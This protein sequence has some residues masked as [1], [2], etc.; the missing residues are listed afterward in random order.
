MMTMMMIM[1]D[2]ASSWLESGY[3]EAIAHK[4]MEVVSEHKE[5]ITFKLMPQGDKKEEKEEEEE[6]EEEEL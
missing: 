6:E 4:L 1:N 3:R 5:T 2:D